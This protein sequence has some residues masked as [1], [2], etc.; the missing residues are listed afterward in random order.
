MKTILNAIMLLLF[1]I[2][3]MH[4]HKNTARFDEIGMV[5]STVCAI[6]CAAVPLVLTG[7]PLVGL[8]FLAMP[9]VEWGMIA[10]ALIV[11]LYSIGLSYWRTHKRPLP[12]I[13]LLGGFILIAFGYG[14]LHG[15]GEGFVVP[16]GGLLIAL[17]H[18]VN[19]RFAGNCRQ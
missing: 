17:A 1:Y 3:G 10:F 19:Y 4:F 7:L 13:L 14:F 5:A 9:W 15:R 18:L 6:H 12:V 16:T 8:E 11:G 2:C